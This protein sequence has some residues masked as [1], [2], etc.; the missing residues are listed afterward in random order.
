MLLASLIEDIDAT[1][2]KGDTEIEICRIV[3]DSRQVMPGDL[4]VCKGVT[5]D[6]HL[7]AEDAYN[8]GAKAFVTEKELMIYHDDAVYVM[9]PDTKKALSLLS[10]RFFGYP[11]EKL[12][13]IGVTGTKGK[14]TTAYFIKNLFEK[15]GLSCGL[16][17][18]IYNMIGKE[19]RIAERTTPEAY[20]IQSMLYEMTIKNTKALTM[21]V[22]SHAL[23]LGRV[24]SVIFD[25]AVFTNLSQDHLD[26]HKDMEDY[27]FEKTKL[28]EQT[29]LSIVN[30]DDAYG[31]RLADMLRAKSTKLLTISLFDED[32]GIFAYDINDD[33][34]GVSF[35]IRG[36]GDMRFCAGMH[37]IYNVYNSLSA[38]AAALS[39]GIPAAGL[40]NKLSDI[41]VPGRQEKYN[42]PKGDNI[43]IDYAH[44]PGSLKETLQTFLGFKKGRLIVLFGAGG[45]RDRTKRPLMGKI[46]GELADLT[47]ITSD[48]PRTED[49]LEIIAQIQ[50]GIKSVDNANYVVIPDRRAAIRFVVSGAQ[51]DDIIILAGKGHETYQEINGIKYHMDEREILDEIYKE[52]G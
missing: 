7:F 36:Y 17:G 20:E 9:T 2:I 8:K 14:T 44:S 40:G 24:H 5:G 4:F 13:T 1:Y 42:N 46:A 30:I 25:A 48:N 39:Y 6:G 49:P 19:K 33:I 50:E 10:R 45:D 41:L 31:K 32:A 28:F 26:Y 47:V 43:I 16:I 11:E 37:G 29:K 18:T 51:L 35:K 38:I 15:N 21:E 52:M 27:F 34:K 3:Y 12:F 23:S 22:S